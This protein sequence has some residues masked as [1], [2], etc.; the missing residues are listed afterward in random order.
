MKNL[1][2]LSLK[3]HSISVFRELL[4]DEV[5]KGLLDY[6][7]LSEDADII[8]KADKY[9]SFVSSLYKRGNGNLSKYINKL[10][11][12]SENI[13]VKAVGCKKDVPKILKKSFL[14]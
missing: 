12:E 6:L 8:Q 5:I 11:N 13:Y 4:R 10:V 9:C 14:V 3:I 7:D 1:K 2:E